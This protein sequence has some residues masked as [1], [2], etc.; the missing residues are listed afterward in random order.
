LISQLISV[1]FCILCFFALAI[2]TQNQFKRYF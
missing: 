2:L 1:S